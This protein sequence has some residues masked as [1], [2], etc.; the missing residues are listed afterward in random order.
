MI[1]KLRLP[2]K[3]IKHLTNAVR[4]PMVGSVSGWRQTNVSGKL[5]V[6]LV[7]QDTL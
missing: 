7:A 4:G 5:N 2:L 3:A 6:A 1:R